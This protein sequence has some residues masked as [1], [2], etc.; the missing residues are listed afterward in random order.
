MKRVVLLL[1]LVATLSA[2][3]CLTTTTKVITVGNFCTVARLMFPTNDAVL[4]YL[5]ENDPRLVEDMINQN[6]F[7][8][9]NCEWEFGQ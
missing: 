9:R 5:N 2:G 8:E 3:S 7:G 4:D 6:T 1:L